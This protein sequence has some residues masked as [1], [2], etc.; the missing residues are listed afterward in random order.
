MTPIQSTTLPDH[1]E[2]MRA[3]ERVALWYLGSRGYAGL[4]VGAYLNPDSAI[5]SL[6]RE[7]N[8]QEAQAHR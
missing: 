7:Q 5:A 3:A 4:L 6:E 8:D 1:E 2:R